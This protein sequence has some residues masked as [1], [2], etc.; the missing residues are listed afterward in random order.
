[1][2][3]PGARPAAGSRSLPPPSF[4]LRM[5]VRL[6][7]EVLITYARVRWLLVRRD[8]PAVVA[9]LRGA[10]VD[11]RRPEDACSLGRRLAH[12]VRRV[13]DPLPWDSRCLMRSLV[14]L[15]MLARRGISTDLVIGVQP[16]EQFKAHAW[17]EHG[18][19]ALLPNLGYEPLTTL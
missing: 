16:G 4:P 17:I 10:V 13:L 2:S 19:Q 18:G 11:R 8:T 1:M 3:D 15:A 14:L 5:R 9:A 7:G 6:T 12:P